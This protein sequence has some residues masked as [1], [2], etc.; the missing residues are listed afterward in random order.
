MAKRISILGTTLASTSMRYYT[1]FEQVLKRGCPL[2]IVVCDPRNS[3]V[4]KMLALRSYVTKDPNVIRG[5]IENHLTRLRTLK[6]PDKPELFEVRL[7]PYIT[8]YGIVVI[9]DFDGTAKAYVKLTPFRTTTGQFPSFKV[10][11]AT[12]D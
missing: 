8:P 12:V 4:L 5:N 9:E 6:I 11:N 10:N 2:R 1:E 3:E 7:I